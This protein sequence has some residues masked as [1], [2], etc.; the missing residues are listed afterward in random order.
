MQNYGDVV[1]GVTHC[2]V[3]PAVRVA[4]LGALHLQ[5][6]CSAVCDNVRAVGAAAELLAAS[7]RAAHCGHPRLAGLQLTSLA[8]VSA[9]QSDAPRPE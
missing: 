8:L 6:D 7:G 9:V 2:L 4:T 1:L 5:M 3:H